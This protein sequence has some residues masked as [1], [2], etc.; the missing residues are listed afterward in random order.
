MFSYVSI[1]VY[2]VSPAILF[3][4]I[5]SELEITL[6]NFIVRFYK[7]F[8]S[9]SKLIWVSFFISFGISRGY[10]LVTYFQYA[11]F[12]LIISLVKII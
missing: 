8:I 9:D 4:T 6:D 11:I 1:V 12:I 5:S 2:V 10:N 7:I 3:S